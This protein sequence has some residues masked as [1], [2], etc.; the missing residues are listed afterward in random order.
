MDIRCTHGVIIEVDATGEL[1]LVNQLEQFVVTA[2]VDYIFS[3]VE[4][5][6]TKNRVF[7]LTHCSFRSL[8]ASTL[9]KSIHLYLTM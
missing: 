4:P 8:S 2:I 3:F 5:R 9:S 7:R 1:V 6:T